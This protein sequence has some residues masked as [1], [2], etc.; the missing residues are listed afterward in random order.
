MFRGQFDR[1]EDA[2]RV[3]SLQV[4]SACVGLITLAVVESDAAVGSSPAVALDA[5]GR[6]LVLLRPCPLGVSG[7]DLGD[8]VF[9]VRGAR[10]LAGD[11]TGVFTGVFAVVFLSGVLTKDAPCLRLFFAGVPLRTGFPFLSSSSSLLS[12]LSAADSS[13]LATKS[14]SFSD[15]LFWPSFSLAAYVTF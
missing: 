2:S 4:R 15:S 1:V 8:L 9:G 10:D 12:S 7:G 13:S 3:K 6:T 14:S 5:A 11:L